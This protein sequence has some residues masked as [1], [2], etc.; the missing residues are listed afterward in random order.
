MSAPRKRNGFTL[1]ELS[2]VLVIIGLIVGGVLV[3]RDLMKAAER[4]SMATQLEQYT[5]AIQTFRLKYNAF[6][7][8]MKDAQSIWGTAPSCNWGKTTDGRTCNGNGDGVIGAPTN[9]ERM[10]AAYTFEYYRFWQHLSNAKLIA[11]NYQGGSVLG[12]GD[13]G[14]AEP[15]VNTPVLKN[16]ACVSPFRWES[17]PNPTYLAY[18][19]G[20]YKLIFYVGTALPDDIC[21]LPA[22][23]PTDALSIDT[24]IDDG[25][26]G[27]GGVRTLT[28]IWPPTANCATSSNPSTARYNTSSTALDCSLIFPRVAP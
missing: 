8:D 15:G 24:K 3:G 5:T 22:F 17:S 18:Y 19:P 28:P 16:G 25:L 14:A 7:G 26:P 20:S 6:P 11:G 12:I 10:N 1:I 9:A 23:T 2:L 27:S 4:R 21:Y 13:Y